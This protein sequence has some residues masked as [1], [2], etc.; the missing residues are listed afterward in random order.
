MNKE[1]REVIETTRKE[2]DNMEKKT[3]LNNDHMELPEWKIESLKIESMKNM[4][5]S[6]RNREGGMRMLSIFSYKNCRMTDYRKWEAMFEILRSSDWE[7]TGPTQEY[8][9]KCTPIKVTRERTKHQRQ[10][11]ESNHRENIRKL[12]I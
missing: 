8:Q 9:N 3:D 1:L 4:N 6:V 5:K 11:D 7:K 2:Q 10:N 12:F